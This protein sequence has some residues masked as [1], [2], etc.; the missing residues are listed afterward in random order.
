MKFTK[1][2]N[3]KMNRKYLMDFM[4]YFL[5]ELINEQLMDLKT[6]NWELIKITF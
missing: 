4:I 5:G 2:E 3:G 1:N 6:P